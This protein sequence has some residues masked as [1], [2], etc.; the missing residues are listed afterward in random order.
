MVYR[1]LAIGTLLTAS[2]FAQTTMFPKPS[3]FRETFRKA[4]TKVELRAPSKLQDF[5]VNGTLQLSRKNYLE[6]VMANNT[7]VQ[8][9]FLTLE[10]AKNNIKSVYGTWDPTATMS[11][12]PNWSRSDS[13]DPRMDSTLSNSRTLPLTLGASQTLQTGGSYTAAF[14]GTKVAS[15][16][17]LNG[18][19]NPSYTTAL[20]LSFTQPLLRNRGLYVNRLPLM[21]AQS[22]S[23]ISAVTLRQSIL[24]QVYSAETAYWA[25][26][27]AVETE[28]TR[29]SG[30]DA[31]QTYWDYVQQQFNLGAVSYL[32]T[33]NPQ[34]SLALAK[35]NYTQSQFNRRNAETALRKYI[36]ADL[37][38]SIRTLPISLTEAVDLN[39]SED[40]VP[41]AEEQVAKAYKLSPALAIVSERLSA[42]DITLASAQNKILPQLDLKLASVTTGTGGSY[43]AYASSGILGPVANSGVGDALGR[44][45]GL[46]SPSYTATLSLSLPLRNRTASATLANALISKKSDALSV[47]TQ[48]QAIRVSVLSAVTSLQ[49]A[50]E[51]LA[52][53]KVQQDFAGKN[54]D[55]MQTKYKLGTETQQNVVS[56][57]QTKVEADLQVV[58]S[59]ISLRNA[60]LNLL[61][62]TGDLLDQRGIVI[63]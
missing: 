42:D 30:L 18:S 1:Y 13:S 20:S 31:S 2:A 36:G 11:L 17:Y 60:V 52:L 21:S 35:L 43:N 28:K 61:T 58:N 47:R 7:D 16:N 23:R 22:S 24:S 27:S 14:T 29:K 4:D 19:N 59:K 62:Q 38:A 39:P 10:T 56:A 48:Q 5:V 57:Q 6:L 55:A 45:F 34:T 33:Y 54:Y 50:K 46:Y 12:A 15:T 40:V 26:V 8:I 51:S 44:M 9:Q 41:D 32:D 3:Y 53:A 37:D 49:S 25:L 63:Q